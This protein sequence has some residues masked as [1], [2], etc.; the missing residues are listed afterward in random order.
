VRDLPAL[1]KHVGRGARL[2]KDLDEDEAYGFMR[3]AV[4]GEADEVQIGGFL[5]AQRMKGESAAELAGFVRGLREAVALELPGGAPD[6]D[7]DLHADGREGRPSLALAAACLAAA[8][9]ARVLL[10]GWFGSRFARNDL[11]ELFAR[12]GVGAGS[13]DAG[14]AIADLAAYAPRI[15]ELLALRERLGVRSCVHSAVKLLDPLAA[16]RV[17]VGI[18]HSPYHAPVAGAALRLGAL[19]AAVVQAPG[20]LPELAP[21]RPT[22]VSRVDG[23]AVLDPAA[24]PGAAPAL[25]SCEDASSLAALIEATLAGHGPPGAAACAVRTAALYLWAA[26]GGDETA[27][28]S[29]TYAALR[30]GAGARVLA[31]LRL[32]Y[33]S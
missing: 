16:R 23:G 28:L 7:V 20:G 26:R 19:R 5:I 14:V 11:G 3:A 24:L 1:I 8:C 21:D 17:A 18:F 30:G 32:C 13:L 10:R 15:A 29:D 4:R 31:A 2:A 12:L 9:G 25:P 6:V 33:R 22:R 27:L